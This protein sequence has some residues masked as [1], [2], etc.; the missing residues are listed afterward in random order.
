MKKIAKNFTAICLSFLML[1]SCV[2]ISA[3]E[4]KV[5]TYA[6]IIEST[7]QNISVFGRYDGLFEDDLYVK[8]YLNEQMKMCKIL[9]KIC[10]LRLLVNL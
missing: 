5:P 6:E 8:G 4:E 9:F 10:L 3:Q 1:L 7:A 2:Q